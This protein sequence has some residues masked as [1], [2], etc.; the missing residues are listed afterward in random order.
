MA[1]NQPESKVSQVPL[2]A[3]QPPQAPQDNL[4]P[5]DIA[6]TKTSDPKD[7]EAAKKILD[8]WLE[9]MQKDV[10][11][12]FAKNGITIYQITILHPG[13]KSPMFMLSG[14]NYLTARLAVAAARELRG[15]VAEELSV[16][17]A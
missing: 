6:I 17:N 1:E 7:I 9:D 10:S 13:T 2:A 3:S 14:S 8:A 11:E 15:R 5:W 4:K 12:L 16:D